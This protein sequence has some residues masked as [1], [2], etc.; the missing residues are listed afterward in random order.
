MTSKR[1]P[2]LIAL[3][4]RHLVDL[5]NETGEKAFE[6][7]ARALSQ[8]ISPGRP[9]IDDTGALAEVESL[10]GTSKVHSLSHALEIV[11]RAKAPIGKKRAFKE[12]LRRKLKAK[13][14][15]TKTF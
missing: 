2:N 12:R 13:E 7:A 6:R 1:K 5:A 10:L 3:T 8:D 14:I 11:A 15:S 9:S 4:H